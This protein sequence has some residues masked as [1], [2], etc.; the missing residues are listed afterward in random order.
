MECKLI[1]LSNQSKI[2]KAIQGDLVDLEAQVVQEVMEA[3]TD[4][5]LSLNMERVEML[6]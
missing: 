4:S 1:L 2:H 6:S 3:I 5:Q